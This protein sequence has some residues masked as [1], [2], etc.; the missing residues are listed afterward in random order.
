[1]ATSNPMHQP[2]FQSRFQAAVK[3]LQAW[4]WRTEAADRRFAFELSLAWARR[5]IYAGD[6]PRSC[7]QQGLVWNLWAAFREIHGDEP[8]EHITVVF[9]AVFNYWLRSSEALEAMLAEN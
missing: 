9:V 3:W 1:M 4:P 5:V 7:D 2:D 6:D 8:S